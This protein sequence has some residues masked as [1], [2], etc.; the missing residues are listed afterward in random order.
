M[1]KPEHESEPKHTEDDITDLDVSGQDAESVK[2]GMTK[3]D[4]SSEPVPGGM[5]PAAR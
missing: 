4:F 1:D 2:G 3:Q 5:R